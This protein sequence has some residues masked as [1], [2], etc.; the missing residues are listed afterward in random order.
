MTPVVRGRLSP[1]V[2]APEAG[3]RSEVL[4]QLGG[5]VVEY[6]LSGNLSS[7]VDYDQPHDEWVV[8]LDGAAVLE[9]NDERVALG[10]GD[11]VL[12][13]AHVPHRLVHTEPGTRWLALHA[14]DRGSGNRCG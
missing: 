12:L 14:S 8:V 3:E 9:V 6:I 2:E 5:A 13:P 4:A 7:P 11:W 10:S 1:A